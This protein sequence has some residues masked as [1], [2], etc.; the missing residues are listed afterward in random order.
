MAETSD[1]AGAVGTI[2]TFVF[3]DI[4]TTGLPKFNFGKAN[5]TELAMWTLSREDFLRSEDTE[6]RLLGKWKSVF[7]PGR[8]INPR[9]SELT[10]LNN[11]MLEDYEKFDVAA[12]AMVSYLELHPKP[13]CLI[14][15]NGNEHDFPI[16]KQYFDKI[17]KKIPGFLW[18]SD[19]LSIFKELNSIAED[20]LL[21]NVLSNVEESEKSSSQ[22]AKQILETTISESEENSDFLNNF[23]E[24]DSIKEEDQLLVN[25][26]SNFEESEKLSPQMAEQIL[27]AVIS[28]SEE[29]S[30]PLNDF[31][32][33]DSIREEDQLLVNVLI[34]VEESEKSSS[35]MAEQ[36]L[37]TP[38]S[39]SE[40][41]SDFLNNFRELDSIKGEDQLLVNVLSNVEESEK[42]SAQM[43]EQI[44]ESAVSNIEENSDSLSNFRELDSIKEEDR[45]L[46]NV[47]SNFV[48][49]EKLSPQMAEQILKTPVSDSEENSDF[50]SN[51]RELD[52][53]K[54]EQLLVNVLSNVEESEKF[55]PQMPEQILG[56][57]IS[58]SEENSDSLNNFRELDSIKEE[59]QLLVNVLSNVEESEKLSPQIAEQ[60]LETTVSNSELN[61]IEDH[62]NSEGLSELN[63]LLERQR[64]NETTPKRNFKGENVK[65][66]KSSFEENTQNQSIKLNKVCREL[67]P[68]EN[69]SYKLRDVYKRIFNYYPP[70]KHIA[71]ADVHTLFEAAR[72][73][74]I[75][76]VKLAEK[77]A[78]PFAQIKR[79]VWK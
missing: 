69:K 8:S 52:S 79:P 29:N 56:A 73:Y 76:F 10:G 34:N 21:V 42:L 68:T 54:E 63:E 59:D 33:L 40:E 32:E 2:R 14:A 61:L 47:L 6:C 12:K 48:E 16:I 11:E 39:D 5:I 50:L 7:R 3:L 20:R 27:K 25:V 23:R 28:N 62:S 49:S 44:L 60:I 70:Y 77:N 72:K 67:F 51:F 58:D 15:H 53:I 26:L 74:G 13:I 17:N 66:Y 18:C 30:D 78:I 31:R 57:V 22:M 75:E 37:K 55:S 64:I 36:I 45:L 46:V 65:K 9:T 1:N 24:L 4:E 71:E 41:N 35:L 19:S 38:V 43:A